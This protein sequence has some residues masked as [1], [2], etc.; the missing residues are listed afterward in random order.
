MR[1]R[2]FSSSE[3]DGWRCVVRRSL[4]SRAVLQPASPFVFFA[5]PF[6][7]CLSPPCSDCGSDGCGGTCG[8]CGDSEVCSGAQVCLSSVPLVPQAPVV[9]GT[10]SGGLAGSFFG[11]VA[12][13]LACAGA[14]WFFGFGG[15]A[16]FDRWRF[17][18]RAS[19]EA[20]AGSKLIGGGAS[21]RGAVAASAAGTG[22]GAAASAASP[23][24][25]S[26][27]FTSYG[28]YGTSSS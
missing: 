10:D 21:G 17:G 25:S 1:Q 24:A 14:L 22:A 6:R 13:S 20:E 28:G 4:G 5:A 3:S 7:V 8:T 15:R 9:Y 16:S 19:E 11:G 23:G 18:A 27:K 26:S 12:A 2:G